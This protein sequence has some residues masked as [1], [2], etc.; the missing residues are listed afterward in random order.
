MQSIYS[1]TVSYQAKSVVLGESGIRFSEGLPSA[2]E[3]SG[4]DFITT[5]LKIFYGKT[6]SFY[7]G[8]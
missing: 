7:A 4:I 6:L 2:S 8:V 1:F 3:N 5:R